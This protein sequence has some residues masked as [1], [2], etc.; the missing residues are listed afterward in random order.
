MG[1]KIFGKEIVA[2][3]NQDESTGRQCNVGQLVGKGVDDAAQIV[4]KETK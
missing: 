3:E 4:G 1:E 2:N